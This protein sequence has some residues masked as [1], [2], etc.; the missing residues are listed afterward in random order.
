LILR[1]HKH[2]KE[3]KVMN[4]KEFG[5][6]MFCTKIFPFAMMLIACL[7]IV[8]G[9]ASNKNL[10][11]NPIEIQDNVLTVG[12]CVISTGDCVIAKCG[13]Y[14]ANCAADKCD[15]IALG[16]CLVGNC[17]DQTRDCIEEIREIIKKK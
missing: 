11:I 3:E 5:G 7:I 1:R 13:S 14:I 15:P 10:V 8:L 16:V 17:A 12:G 6:K 4:N 2:F 9:C